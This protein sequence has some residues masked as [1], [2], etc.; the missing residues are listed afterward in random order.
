MQI[1]ILAVGTG[2]GA[3]GIMVSSYTLVQ[4]DRL[5]TLVKTPAIPNELGS[6][7]CTARSV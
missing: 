3:G 1:T 4:S 6:L 2:I 7:H 5:L